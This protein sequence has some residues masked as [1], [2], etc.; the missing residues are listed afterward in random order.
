MMKIFKCRRSSLALIGMIGL[1]IISLV[2][3]ID[4][5]SAIAAICIGVAGANAY[6]GKHEPKA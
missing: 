1:G 5:S 6:E 2:K 3:S 4:T